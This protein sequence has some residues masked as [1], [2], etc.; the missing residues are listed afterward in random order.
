[1]SYTLPKPGTGDDRS[2]VNLGHVDATPD[3]WADA[4]LCARRIA[5]RHGHAYGADEAGDVCPDPEAHAA[6]V[7]LLAEVLT[8]IRPEDKHIVGA[9]KPRRRVA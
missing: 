8:M 7:A 9:R 3:E 2:I 4:E 6:D 5:N 1:M